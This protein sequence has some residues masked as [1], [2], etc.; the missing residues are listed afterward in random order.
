MPFIK[1][2]PILIQGTESAYSLVFDPDSLSSPVSLSIAGNEVISSARCMLG[3]LSDEMAVADSVRATRNGAVIQVVAK[4]NLP[5]GAQPEFVHTAR[6]TGQTLRVTT[7]LRIRPRTKIRQKVEIGS[8]LVKGSWS[9]Y[10]IIKGEAGQPLQKGDWQPITDP[11]QWPTPPLAILLRNPDGLILE[12]GTGSDLWRWHDGLQPEVANQGEYR[13]TRTDDG[14]HFQ[15]LVTVIKGEPLEP[16][17]RDYR[18]SW[19]VSWSNTAEKPQSISAELPKVQWTATGKLTKPSFTSMEQSAAG[20]L[21]DLN[22]MVAGDTH[23]HQSGASKACFIGKSVTKRLRHAIRQIAASPSQCPLYFHGLEPGVCH[24]GSH[25]QRNRPLAHWDIN[26]IIDVC[27]WIRH[28]LGP[29]RKLVLLSS[30]PLP[31]LHE[32]F[33]SSRAEL[34]WEADDQF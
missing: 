2:E 18:F 15:R 7:D 32:A 4:G 10:A 9:D 13:L 3:D 5:F 23:M 31:S 29:E 20:V 16:K 26:H 17:P 14:I 28:A 30:L 22:E 21:L 8:L 33:S 1:P 19:Y 12:L 11:L 34:P 6:A 27:H 24:E 25:P